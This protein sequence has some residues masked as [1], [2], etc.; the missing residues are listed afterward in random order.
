MANGSEA[1]RYRTARDLAP[2]GML[3]SEEMLTLHKAALDAASAQLIVKKQRAEVKVKGATAEDAEREQIL[4]GT[5][6]GNLLCTGPVPAMEVTDAGTIPHYRRLLQMGYTSQMRPIRLAERVLFRLLSR[7]EHPA[8][9]FE[10]EELADWE[11]LAGATWARA[12]IREAA[13]AALAEAGHVEDPRVRGSAH[14]IA[15]DVSAFLRSPL[16]DNP[17]SK[18]GSTPVLHPDAHPPSWSSL[19]MFAA[20][21][22]LRRERSGFTERLCKYL[23]RKADQKTVAVQLGKKSVK[24]THLLL[25]D[26]IDTDEKGNAKDVPVALAF[27]ELFIGIGGKLSEAPN[28][29]DV[30]A[31]LFDDCDEKGVWGPKGLRSQPKSTNPNVFHLWPLAEEEKGP[32]ARQADVTFHLARLAKLLGWPITYS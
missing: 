22:N 29:H 6:A 2:A 14:T 4:L 24:P 18:P 27:I 26:P 15:N 32:A 21:P 25:G 28:A 20:M 5:W 3:S 11:P 1:L 19:S 10:Y 30:L 23:S 16:A 12:L 17:F 31:R 13:T 8:L 7:D 9:Y